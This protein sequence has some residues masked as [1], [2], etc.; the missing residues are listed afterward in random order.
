MRHSA[1]L[2]TPQHAEVVF[3]VLP[4]NPHLAIAAVMIH[5]VS[6]DD[7]SKIS[8]AIASVG[9]SA[10]DW[11]PPITKPAESPSAPE[12]TAE[13]GPVNPAKPESST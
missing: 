2:P 3:R 6:F 8:A 13:S 12:T 10:L 1:V 7:A 9:L 4:G 11:H 5:D